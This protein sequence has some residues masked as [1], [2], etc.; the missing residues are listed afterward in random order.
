AEVTRGS[1]SV[2]AKAICARL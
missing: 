2:Q 1:R